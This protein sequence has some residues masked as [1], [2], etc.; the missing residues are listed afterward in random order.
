[1]YIEVE[2]SLQ[3]VGAELAKTSERLAIGHANGRSMA[4][5]ASSQVTMSDIPIFHMR[6]KKANAVKIKGA[7]RNS[8]SSKN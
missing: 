5:C 6:V 4:Y 1:M 8:Q 7:M 2:F 3:V